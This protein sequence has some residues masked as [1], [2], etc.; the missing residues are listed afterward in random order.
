MRNLNLDLNYLKWSI[1][2]HLDS[3]KKISPILEYEIEIENKLY[4]IKSLASLY[5][6]LDF[7]L[8]LTAENSRTIFEEFYFYQLPRVNRRIEKDLKILKDGIEGIEKSPSD[9]VEP[10]A[11]VDSFLRKCELTREQVIEACILVGE[12]KDI[13][14]V[15]YALEAINELEKMNCKVGINTG[16][17]KQA[18]EEVSRRK[19]GIE[20]TNIAC[21]EFFYDKRGF[22]I[23]SWLNLGKNKERSMSEY[24]LPEAYCN[25][26]LT[27][28][29]NLASIFYVTDDLS[30]F[31]SYVAT[32]IG[33]CLGSILYVGKNF[34]KYEKDYEYVVNAP[35]IRKDLRK[36]KPYFELIR[37]ARIYPFLHKPEEV[38]EII[39]LAEE[40]NFS[41]YESPEELL[42]KIQ[43]FISAE[44]LFP[45]LT[46]RIDRRCKELRKKLEEKNLKKEELEE[47]VR[48]LKSFDPAF[49]VKNERKK[50]LR[51]I[52]RSSF[53]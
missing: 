7:D 9:F 14:I 16:S 49:H 12:S 43:E 39:K 1:F 38:E 18:V 33:S 41:N 17:I 37:R 5:C 36:I 46:T 52:I 25:F 2:Y 4:K 26:S 15:P 23:K 21:T 40:I 42:D 45:R 32:K 11:K 3:I 51:E 35:E 20:A 28:N 31:E 22:F 53:L 29:P 30:P 10:K 19:I 27:I 34:E 6:M 44:I 13:K 48:I 50:E 8:T 24:F 47:V